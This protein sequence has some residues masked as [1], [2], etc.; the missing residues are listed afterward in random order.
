M[1]EP[2]VVTA[3]V[4]WLLPPV[5]VPPLVSFEAPVATVTVDD[6]AAV[7]VPETVQLIEAPEARLATGTVGVQVPTVTP[8]GKP[9]MAQVAVTAAF[10]PA[11]AQTIVPE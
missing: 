5:V 8:A 7:G 1:S 10:G 2:T 9:E 11:L 6:P 3:L 4:A